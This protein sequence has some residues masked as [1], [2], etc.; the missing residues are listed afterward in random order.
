MPH[1]TFHVTY[2][3]IRLLKASE[4]A[5]YCGMALAKFKREC[6]YAPIQLAQNAIRY[7]IQDLDKWID[8]LK[9]GE[10]ESSDEYWLSKLD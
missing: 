8:G 7:D 1:A 6:P 10:D 4:A 5:R 3:P 2:Q 9:L